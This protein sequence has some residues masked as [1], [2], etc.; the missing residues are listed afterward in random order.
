MVE[1]AA[2]LPLILLNGNKRFPSGILERY[3]ATGSGQSKK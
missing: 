2:I 1:V 3:T